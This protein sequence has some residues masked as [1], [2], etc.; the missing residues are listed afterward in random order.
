VGNVSPH[1]ANASRATWRWR[2]RRLSLH[3]NRLPHLCLL[4]PSQRDRE[5][6]F[7]RGEATGCTARPQANAGASPLSAPS[8]ACHICFRGDRSGG[9]PWQESTTGLSPMMA[10]GRTSSTMSSRNPFALSPLLSLQPRGLPASN[11]PAVTLPTSS[12]RTK[13]V[14]GIPNCPKGTIGRMPTSF[15]N[16]LPRSRSPSP[17]ALAR[18]NSMSS[19]NGGACPAAQRL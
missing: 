18:S 17:A 3:W 16:E 1:A 11:I 9:K 12:I 2:R 8:I 5:K 14:R 10:A 15:P 13:L 6:W 7:R 19:A 4:S